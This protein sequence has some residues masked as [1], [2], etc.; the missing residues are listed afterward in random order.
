MTPEQ[1]Q[2]L[3][4]ALAKGRINEDRNSQDW[5]FPRGWNAGVEF[6][7]NQIAKILKEGA[8]A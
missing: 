3:L 7:E 4:E 6:A 8:P 1:L 2:R 5:P